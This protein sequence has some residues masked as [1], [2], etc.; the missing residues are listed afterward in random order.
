MQARPS[1]RPS[2]Q[3]LFQSEPAYQDKGIKCVVDHPDTPRVGGAGSIARKIEV[4]GRAVERFSRLGEKH[5]RPR[6]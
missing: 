3:P 4:S 6:A 5:L 1:L 2:A